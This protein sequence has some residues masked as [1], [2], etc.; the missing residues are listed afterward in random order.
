M[1][2]APVPIS[3]A[4]LAALLEFGNDGMKRDDQCRQFY[5]A[6]P[7]MRA[8]IEQ[9]ERRLTNESAA[10]ANNLETM[11]DKV[12]QAEARLA[13]SEAK[14]RAWDALRLAQYDKGGQDPTCWFRAYKGGF[15]YPLNEEMD[16]LL[17]KEQSNG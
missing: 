15:V 8:R 2:N 17:A 5:E 14:A 10:Y 7:A 16:R 4:E 6:F 11:A 12:E 3:D 13:E 9:A 1:S